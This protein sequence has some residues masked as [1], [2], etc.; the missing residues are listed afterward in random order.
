MTE[1]YTPDEH[2]EA[3][4][5]IDMMRATNCNLMQL[6]SDKYKFSEAAEA[7]RNNKFGTDETLEQRL[8]TLYVSPAVKRSIRQTLRIVDEITDIRKAAPEK[9]F[10]EMARGADES[11]KG[12]RTE[13]R[14]N[15]LIHFTR[16]AKRTAAHCMRLSSLSLR[17][18]C[19]MTHC[20]C[21]I[22]NSEDVCT[23]AKR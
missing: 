6:M 12:K 18:G 19:V 13:S 17:D 8:D 16:R 15:R 7:Y 5:V 20:I 22:L 11:Q 21:T 9:I 3:L 2:G 10:I 1:L 14:K 23:R 4:S